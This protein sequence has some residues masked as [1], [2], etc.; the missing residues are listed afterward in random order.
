[1]GLLGADACPDLVKGHV[2]AE[3]DQTPFANYDILVLGGSKTPTPS[4]PW[5]IADIP[6]TYDPPVTNPSQ[7]VRNQIG[8]IE[9][10]KGLLSKYSCIIQADDAT[11]KPRKLVNIAKS[12]ILYLTGQ[13]SSHILYNQCSV[14]FLRQA[15]V[16]VT[17]T[18]LEDIG[19]LGNGHFS[20]LEKNSDE[21]ATYI[22]K[23]LKKIK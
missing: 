12:P 7:L 11:H 5:G 8:K 16:S 20:M 17:W 13:A 23:W 15:G 10:T 1:M 14:Q 18:K 22:E 3:G 19:I 4:R 6:I 21:I 2:T 9:F